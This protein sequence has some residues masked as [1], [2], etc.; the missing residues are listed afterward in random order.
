MTKIHLRS[1]FFAFAIM[2]LL[3]LYSCKKDQIQAVVW[4]DFTEDVSDEVSE[5]L[6]T[7][8]EQYQTTYLLNTSSKKIHKTNCGTANLMSA[9][10]RKVYKC[11]VEDLFQQGYTYCGN[12]FK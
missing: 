4:D 10:N 3:Y 11:N 7:N 1:L 6:Q 8:Y 5:E 12:C 2:I 9:K